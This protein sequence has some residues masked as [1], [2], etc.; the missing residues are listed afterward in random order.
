MRHALT[1]QASEGQ[2]ALELVLEAAVL[3]GANSGYL[4]SHV[5]P[6]TTP[7]ATTSTSILILLIQKL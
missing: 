1:P 5:P 7:V 2:E 6:F 4:E 3:A